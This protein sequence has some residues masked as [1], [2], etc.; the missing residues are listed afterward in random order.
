VLIWTARDEKGSVDVHGLSAVDRTF[1]SKYLK[2]GATS[3]S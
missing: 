2:D 3:R 1:E